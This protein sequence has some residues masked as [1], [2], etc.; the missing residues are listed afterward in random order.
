[1]PTLLAVQV[2]QPKAHDFH[3]REWTSAIDKTSVMGRVALSQK[4]LTGDRQFNLKFHGGVDKAVCCY[5]A[6]HY[7]MWRELLGK[8]E[9]FTSGAFGENFTVLDMLEEDV[10]IGDVYEIGSAV[11][12]VS[13]PRQPCI[14]LARK[15]DLRKLPEMMMDNGRT[16]YYLR[17]QQTGEVSAGDAF[18]LRERPCPDLSVLRLNRVMYQDEGDS[19]LLERLAVLPELAASGRVF[20]R[21]LAAK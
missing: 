1:M 20:Q 13:Q 16:G 17:V 15:W 10:C 18:T 4:N 6:E 2:G 9:D 7:P 14:N 21:M 19:E 11:V 8:A 5:C 12:Q 3:G